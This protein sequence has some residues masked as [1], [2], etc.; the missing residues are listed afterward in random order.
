[1]NTSSKSSLARYLPI[2]ARVVLGIIFLGSGIFG[3]LMAL[4][5]V[6]MPPPQEPMS[7]A[8]TAFTTGLFKSGYLFQLI[9]ATEIVGGALLLANRYTPLALILLAPIVVNILAVH[10]LLIH[11][12][13]PIAIVVVA[14]EAYLGWAYR[15]S[16]RPLFVARPELT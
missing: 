3:M 7:E 9:K 14:L 8:A 12:G 10:V 4:G 11:S 16:F 6:P 2:V 13:L 1:M 5:I 15:G